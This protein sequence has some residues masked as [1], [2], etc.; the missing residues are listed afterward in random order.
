MNIVSTHD[1]HDAHLGGAADVLQRPGR[2]TTLAQTVTITTHA[3]TERSRSLAA[4]SFGIAGITALELAVYPS[5]QSTSAGWRAMLDQWPDALKQAFRLDAYASGT[6][7]L[8]TELF[9]MMFPIVLIAVAIG[10]AAGATA[11]EEERGTADLLLSLPIL[12]GQLLTAKV[13]AM[14]IGVVVVGL[15]GVATIIVGAPMVQLDV[16][17]VE[18]LAA[19]LVTVQLGVLFG[20][21][22][23]LVGALTGRRAAALGAGIGLAIAAFLLQVMAPM[24]DW[25]EPWQKASPFYWA[26]SSDPLLNG[27]D[28]AAAALLLGICAALLAATAV[29]FH[30]RD[31]VG[32]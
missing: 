22:A 16:G 29:A 11:G 9:S 8:N 6:G 10:I 32:R 3:V 19:G 17:T 30:H 4:W 15:A 26:T 21:V 23:L 31:I 14:V 5:I 25:L 18:V 27:L 20:C 12:R 1:H 13:L 7:F 28:V 2:P 24:A